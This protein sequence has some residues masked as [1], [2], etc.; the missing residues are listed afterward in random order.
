MKEL[1]MFFLGGMLIVG[2]FIV[3]I[4]CVVV[5]KLRKVGREVK[6]MSKM[7]FGTENI[8]EGFGK[9]EIDSQQTPKSLSGMDSIILPRI[10]KDFPDFNVDVAKSDVRRELKNYLRNKQSVK[11]HN[12]VIR[13]YK[14]HNFESVIIMQASAE[15]VE[16]SRKLQKRYNFNYVYALAGSLSETNIAAVCP[17]CGGP[18]SN[19]SLA[20]CEYC[21]SRLVN[22]IEQ[23]W[24]VKD[25]SEC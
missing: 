22:L 15:Y 8:I 13:D 16:G 6:K 12:V 9:A 17:N 14:K 18:V 5:S 25:I 11:I 2:I 4:V 1:G 20:E 3:I 24:K 21:G 10:K 7:A 23:S 19:T